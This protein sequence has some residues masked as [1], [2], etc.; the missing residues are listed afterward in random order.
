MKE[1]KVQYYELI[2]S[3]TTVIVLF[4]SNLYWYL[5]KNIVN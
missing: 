4:T 1:I 2:V 3:N 5:K